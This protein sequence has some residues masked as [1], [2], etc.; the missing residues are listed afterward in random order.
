MRS[1]ATVAS[2][3]MPNAPPTC[4]VVFTSPEASPESSG[5][6]PD[7]A[8]VISAGN[9][10]P[11]PMP[12]SE[13]R[14]QQVDEVAPVDRRP[15]QQRQPERDQR[16]RREQHGARRRSGV[17]SRAEKPSESVPIATDTGRNAVPVSIA[18]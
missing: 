15:G 12:S 10:S 18:S 5:A 8:S 11:P 2:I 1:A 7:I 3:A 16:E 17:F 13:H 6:T 9:A 4:C 14:R